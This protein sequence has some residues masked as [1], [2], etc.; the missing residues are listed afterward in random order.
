MHLLQSGVDVILI[1]N[2]LGHSDVSTTEIYARADTEMKR[3]ALEKQTRELIPTNE[4]AW[5]TNS[6]LRTWLKSVC[7]TS[8]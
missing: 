6:E 8:K 4:P 7:S 5:H 2:L 1:K 3:H